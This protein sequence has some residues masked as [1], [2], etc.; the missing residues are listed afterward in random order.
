M[1]EIRK[2]EEKKEEKKI[3]YENGPGERFGP[4]P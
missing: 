3:K 1:K 2:T 4:P